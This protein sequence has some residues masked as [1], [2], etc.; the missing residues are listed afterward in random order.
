MSHQNIGGSSGYSFCFAG[1]S[2]PAAYLPQESGASPRK[3][4][5]NGG[6]NHNREKPVKSDKQA[7]V[8]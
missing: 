5:S 4:F 7:G 6:P 2:S 8:G 1:H 3:V